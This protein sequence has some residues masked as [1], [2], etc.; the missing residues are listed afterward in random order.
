[1]CE[2][3]PLPF[4]NEIHNARGWGV[5]L[6][7]YGIGWILVLAGVILLIVSPGG[8][9]AEGFGLAVGSGLSVLL[10]NVLYR[11]GVAGDKEREREEEARQFLAEHG[12]WPEENRR[13][14][15]GREPP[16]RESPGREPP[17]RE[18][19]A[20]PDPHHTRPGEHGGRRAGIPRDRPRPRRRGPE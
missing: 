4:Q 11:L 7:R 15:S 16:G 2:P 9:G 19:P 13:E 6:I 20:L 17:S 14:P 8:F 10:L 12:R 5:W 18:P 1:M 3:V